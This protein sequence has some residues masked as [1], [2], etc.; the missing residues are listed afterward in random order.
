MQQAL[1]KFDFNEKNVWR[2]VLLII[3]KL[4]T[5]LFEEFMRGLFLKKNQHFL[6]ELSE[7][8]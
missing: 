2:K 8:L 6:W 1:L 3:K 4:N 5:N 7:T